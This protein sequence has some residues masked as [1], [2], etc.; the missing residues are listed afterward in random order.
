[1]ES[2][3]EGGFIGDRQAASPFLIKTVNC[4]VTDPM[5]IPDPG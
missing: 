5:F 2:P 1:M 4:S 3:R